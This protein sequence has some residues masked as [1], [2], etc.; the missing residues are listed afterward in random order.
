MGGGS[1][2]LRPVFVFLFLVVGA[3]ALLARALY[4]D[5]EWTRQL[6]DR[7]PLMEGDRRGA[8]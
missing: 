5:P 3:Y 8:R 4:A 6:V 2:S 1:I 7:V